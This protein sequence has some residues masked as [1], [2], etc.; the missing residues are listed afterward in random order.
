LGLP[1][2]SLPLR[3][4]VFIAF[5]V[6]FL[7]ASWR[8]QLIADKDGADGPKP[9]GSAVARMF[10]NFTFF[11]WCAVLMGLSFFVPLAFDTAEAL[12]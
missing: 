2:L 7:G 12:F 4:V 11:D 10:S 5:A 6:G 8:L 3:W 1:T 9:G